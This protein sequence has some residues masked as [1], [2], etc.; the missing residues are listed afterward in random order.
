MFGGMFGVSPF[1]TILHLK[2]ARRRLTVVSENRLVE[3]V[4]S[5][6]GIDSREKSTAAAVTMV[7]GPAKS[8]ITSFAGVTKKGFAPYNPKKRNQDAILMD[9]H[10]PTGSSIFGVFDGHGEEGDVVSNYYAGR[11]ASAVFK[12]KQF[13]EG[14]AF[15]LA[16]ELETCSQ[17]LDSGEED[18]GG[19][20]AI[21]CV[22]AT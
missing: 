20:R 19:G 18:G 4:S 8:R 9:I 5:S 22:Y 3:G 6:T 14:P 15:A 10:E 17:R 2:Q 1:S 16:Q 13:A 12:N 11:L 7:I 21:H